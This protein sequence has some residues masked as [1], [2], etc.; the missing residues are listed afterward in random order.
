MRVIL[1]CTWLLV[2][3]GFLGWHFGPGQSYLALDDS[4]RHAAAARQHVDAGEWAQAVT[5]YDAAIEALPPSAGESGQRLRLERAKAR[6]EASQLIES[7]AELDELVEE[8]KTQ[9]PPAPR[10]LAE[11][12][13]AQASAQY[14]VTWLLRLEG[15]GRDVWEPEIEGARQT[16]RML[17]E[18]ADAR[19]DGTAADGFR[20]DLEASIR[21]ARMDLS[22]LQA[23]SL[24]KQCCGCCNC[25]DGLG[26][27]KGKKK[28][29]K[30]G[31]TQQP[32]GSKA[33]MGKPVEE[34]GD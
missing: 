13:A 15:E 20:R 14:Y 8:L 18:A 22:E 21:L 24:P 26:K 7:Y 5:A 32:E 16:Y 12:E 29:K 11:A 3:V 1:I 10:L 6:L 33:G 19:G 17:A 25:K 28:G 2:P 27:C 9:A 4:A 30:P 23:L 31:S 34:G